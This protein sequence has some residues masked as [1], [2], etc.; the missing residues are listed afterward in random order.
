MNL[1]YACVLDIF[2]EEGI[3]MGKIRI[4]GATKKIPLELLTDA[5]PGDTVL[6]CDGVALAK[7][8]RAEKPVTGDRHPPS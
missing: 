3:R 7:M 8:T 5:A 1:L 4:A 2:T 6:I